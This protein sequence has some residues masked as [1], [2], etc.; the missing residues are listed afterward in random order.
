MNKKS[1]GHYGLLALS[2]VSCLVSSSLGL[3]M[4]TLGYPKS[5]HSMADLL[6]WLLP[7][8]SLV[9]FGLVL[10]AP[11]LGRI[12]GWLLYAGS[13]LTVC[14]VNWQQCI[15]GECTTNS[16]LQVFFS[17]AVSVPHLWVLFIAAL[18]LQLMPSSSKPRK[19][20]QPTDGS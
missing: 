1:W 8:L 4:A 13:L 7:S 12:V 11:F 15:R 3:L 2:G 17:T 14:W 16:L 20:N 5:H 9:A 10:A 19:S 18:S 6:F